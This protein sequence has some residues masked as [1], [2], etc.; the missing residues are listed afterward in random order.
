MP[1]TSNSSDN[2]LLLAIDISKRRLRKLP[3]QKFKIRQPRVT[4]IPQKF[5]SNKGSVFKGDFSFASGEKWI[6]TC[7]TAGVEKSRFSDR[8]NR[9][10][11]NIITKPL[12]NHY[13]NKFQTFV[14]TNTHQVT[15]QSS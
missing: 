5:V 7:T 9:S 15:A 11:K 1:P 6:V 14:N 8:F 3:M 2:F 13:F 4:E 12:E 10:W